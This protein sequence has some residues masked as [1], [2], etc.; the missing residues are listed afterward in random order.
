MSRR[1]LVLP[2]ALGSLS[3]GCAS[4]DPYTGASR[5]QDIAVQYGTVLDAPQV[6]MDSATGRNA[7]LGGAL[8]LLAASSGS[9]AEQAAGAAAGAGLGALIARESAG[10]GQR[11]TIELVNGRNITLVTEQR[12]IAAGDC[13]A[14]EQGAHA[15][16]RRVSSSMCSTDES[17]PAYDAMHGSTQ[18]EAAQCQRAKQELV[19]ASTAEATDIAYKKMRALC[20]H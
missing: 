9:S 5:N 17:H 2:I 10:T 7:I 12:D 15:N 4:T 19:N 20:E 11:Y 14:V 8:G 16:I 6:E 1:S 13:V 3:A 18:A